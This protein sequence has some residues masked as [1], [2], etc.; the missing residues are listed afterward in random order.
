LRKVNKEFKGYIPKHDVVT[1]IKED[2]M[3]AIEKKSNA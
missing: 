2:G 3:K 1:P